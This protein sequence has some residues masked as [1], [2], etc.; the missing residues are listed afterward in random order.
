MLI[1]I[2]WPLKVKIDIRK[3]T[4]G[5]IVTNNTGNASVYLINV[6]YLLMIHKFQLFF[7]NMHSR[8][9]RYILISVIEIIYYVVNRPTILLK[10]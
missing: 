3:Q 5:S 7:A 1:F 4:F 8:L 2:L 9:M 6:L 10:S